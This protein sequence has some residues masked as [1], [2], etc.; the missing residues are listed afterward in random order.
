[1]IINDIY[2]TIMTDNEA[3]KE[4]ITE[5]DKVFDNIQPILQDKVD[6][7]TYNSILDL[8]AS[9]NETAFIQGFK[10]AIELIKECK[11]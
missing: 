1:M 11:I 6:I 9:G 7:D 5:L 8:I 10:V 3:Y 2:L 4:I